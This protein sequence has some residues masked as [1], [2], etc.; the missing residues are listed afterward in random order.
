MINRHAPVLTDIDEIDRDSFEPAYNQLVNILRRKISIGEF[1]P[2]ERLPSEAELCSQY[3]VSSITARRAIKILVEQDIAQTRQ[4]QGTFLK[5]IM[6]GSATFDLQG[7]QKIFGDQR[8]T[9]RILR[10]SAVSADERIANKL[11]LKAGAK[12]IYIH[13]LLLQEK[14]PLMVHREYLILDPKNPTVEAELEVTSLSGLFTGNGQTIFKRGDLVI[15]AT[16]LTKEEA[17]LLKSVKEA[18]A[19]RIEHI[20]YDIYDRVASWG[21]FICRGDQLRFQTTVGVSETV[22]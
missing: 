20:F 14:L 12:V 5:P 10:A 8:T 15:D 6:I 11:N 4:G 3:Q 19:F 17:S 22:G 18:P 7:L 16:V 9:V 1:L 21:W 2:G 13:R